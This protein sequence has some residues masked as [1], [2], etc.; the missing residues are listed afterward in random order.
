MV[1]PLIQMGSFVK[2]NIQFPYEKQLIINSWYK[3]IDFTDPSNSPQIAWI[4]TLAYFAGA[5]ITN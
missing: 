3:D 1:D 2:R 4:N 5:P